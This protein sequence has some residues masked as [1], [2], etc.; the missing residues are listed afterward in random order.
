[1]ARNRPRRQRRRRPRRRP[2]RPPKPRPRQS[3]RAAVH[4]SRGTGGRSEEDLRRRSGARE[5]AECALGITT[6]AQIAA[7]SAEDIARVDEVLNFKGRIERDNWI[8]QAKELA[9]K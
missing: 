9:G 1:V 6:Y 8:E 5:E 2:K 7:F 3:F 4:R